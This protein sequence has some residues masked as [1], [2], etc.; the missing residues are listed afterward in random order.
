MIE[1]K[2]GQLTMMTTDLAIFIRTTCEA[3]IQMPGQISLPVH[4]LASMVELMSGDQIEFALGKL[5]KMQIKCGRTQ[6]NIAGMDTK[7]FPA[8]PEPSGVFRAIPGKT[9][10]GFVKRVTFV[11]APIPAKFSWNA[12]QVSLTPEYLR[13]AASDGNRLAVVKEMGDFGEDSTF[14]IPKKPLVESGR[15]AAN[16]DNMDVSYSQNHVHLRFADTLMAISLM[17]GTFPDFDQILPKSHPYEF[18][19][20]RQEFDRAL[21]RMMLVMSPVDRAAPAVVLNLDKEQLELT[22]QGDDA[23]TAKDFV[24]VEGYDGPPMSIRVNASYIS[25]ACKAF[26][27]YD[28]M[29]VRLKNETVNIEINGD[30]TSDWE[31]R[32]VFMPLCAPATSDE[33]PKVKAAATAAASGKSQTKKQK[34]VETIDAD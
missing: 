2:D 33:T 28:E 32:Y 25:E 10:A 30:K 6:Y 22:A 16:L 23:E 4:K 13:L 12:V 27:N 5:D 29:I 9:W 31:Y 7:H 18:K 8:M 17:A 15:I 24:A 26:D 11:M 3:T 14:L 34:A 1:A 21:D 20:K 19:I